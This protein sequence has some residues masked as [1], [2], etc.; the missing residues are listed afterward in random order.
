MSRRAG[1]YDQNGNPG[2]LYTMSNPP[3]GKRFGAF[4]NG[5]KSIQWA[6]AL[7]RLLSAPP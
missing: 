6:P 4:V 5:G 7:V 1:G 3:P 2:G